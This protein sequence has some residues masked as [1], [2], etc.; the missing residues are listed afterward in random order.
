[1]VFIGLSS[2][3]PRRKNQR[4]DQ[5]RHRY[6]SSVIKISRCQIN[7]KDLKDWQKAGLFASLDDE[8]PNV[9]CEPEYGEL[10]VGRIHPGCSM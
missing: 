9:Q 6:D 2:V 5:G 1:M 10:K 8:G 4:N 3:G 7:C